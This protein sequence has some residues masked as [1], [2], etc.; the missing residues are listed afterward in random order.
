MNIRWLSISAIN[1]LYSTIG[2]RNSVLDQ[3]RSQQS[4]SSK[5]FQTP[6]ACDS[7]VWIL[8]QLA[9]AAFGIL[10]LNPCTSAQAKAPV[11]KAFAPAAPLWRRLT[12]GPYG[13]GLKTLFQYDSSRTWKVTR[14]YD[15]RFSPDLNGRPVQINVWYPVTPSDLGQRMSY[16]GYVDQAAADEFSQFNDTMRQRN[17]EDAVGLVSPDHIVD[18]QKLEMFAR[19]GDQP[20]QGRFPVV[21]YFGGLNASIN[22]NFILAEYLASYGYVFASISILGPSN[23]QTFQSRTPDDLEG[24]VRDM[25]FAWSILQREQFADS[26]KV[27]AIGHSVGAI[28]AVILGLRN[29]NVSFLV[30]LDGTYG[31][32][33]LSSVLSRSYGYDANKMRAAFVD[34]RRAQGAQGNQPLHLTAV[35]SFR[36]ADR[37]FITIDRMHHSDF[38]SSA[39][40]ADYFHTPLPSDYSLNSWT[41]ATGRSGYESTSE[42]MLSEL[43]AKLKANAVAPVNVERK[44]T[45]GM[46]IRHEKAIPPPPSPLEAATLASTQGMDGVKAAFLTSCGANGIASCIDL[47]RFN[48]WGYNLLGQ[49]RAQAG[50]VVFEL[51]AW[52]HPDNANLQDSLADGF[53]AV[54]DKDHARQTVQHAID[55]APSDPSFDSIEARLA[56]L[57]E[58]ESKLQQRK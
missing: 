17:R 47:D 34:V 51:N 46:T 13:V 56:F 58:E 53:S 1:W 33:G 6:I 50:L 48:T 23:E 9:S 3:L 55:L 8:R 28:E 44:I 37:T 21:L 24:T 7:G 41:R 43:D 57:A 14:D 2:G 15:R 38:A 42:L 27:A 26:T 49:G 25:E 29:S 30:G 40:I 5:V 11:T 35:A 45:A 10:I 54:G 19:P 32:V 39:M 52:A 16:A 31:F 12:P 20:A 36:R 18:L 22:S 4:W